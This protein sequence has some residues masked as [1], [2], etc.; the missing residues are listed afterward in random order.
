MGAGVQG[1]RRPEGT[2]MRAGKERRPGGRGGRGANSL[3]E[4]EEDGGAEDE[5][6][7]ERED[8]AV[9]GQHEAAAAVEAVAAREHLPLTPRPAAQAPATTA[10]AAPA[11][12]SGRG[13]GARSGGRSGAGVA[14]PGGGG[15][16][17]GPGA[18]LLVLAV[19]HAAGR[20]PR[21]RA[22]RT[23][24]TAP[25]PGR[26]AEGAA[27][28]ASLAGGLARSGW[29]PPLPPRPPPRLSRQR[30]PRRAR[31]LQ[32]RPPGSLRAFALRAC[33]RC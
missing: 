24:R 4:E 26:A 11:R 1:G 33:V 15:R 17:G 21:L 10:A 5:Q 2:Q 30:L 25:G 29:P 28:R 22:P 20:G 12:C 13:P 23:G 3:E 9:A 19:L 32:V 7:C 14:R 18:D 8:A 27:A 6:Q 31:E 16:R